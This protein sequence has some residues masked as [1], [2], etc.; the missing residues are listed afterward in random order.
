MQRIAVIIPYY[1]RDSGILTRSLL[2][3]QDQTRFSSIVKII[4]VDDGSPAPAADE[5][6]SFDQSFLEKVQLIKKENGGVS[7]ARNTALDATPPEATIIAFLDSDDCWEPNHIDVM[8][9]AFSFGADFYFTNF[10]QLNSDIG[11]FERNK[12]LN[13]SDHNQLNE[14]LFDYQG[15]MQDQIATGNLIGTPTVAYL[16]KKFERKRFKEGFSCA[17]E[18]YLFWMEIAGE[19]PKIVFCNK[20]M[21]TCNEGVNIYSSAKWGTMHLQKLIRDEITYRRYL[22]SHY[23]LSSS[24][25]EEVE[26]RI[27]QGSKQFF[28]N[29]VSCVKNGVFSVIPYMIVNLV[30]M[31]EILTKSL[32]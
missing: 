6:R 5:L 22:I 21:V 17:G 10:Y 28:K 3:I 25:R 23:E 29:A 14:Y 30:R 2:S 26:G 18:D 9:Q 31:P 27:T 32:K 16:H 15:N 20:C 24:A 7:K 13:L 8:E 19:K 11:A 12:K 4:I 1:Q